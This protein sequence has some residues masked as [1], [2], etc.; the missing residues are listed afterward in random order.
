MR[1]RARGAGELPGHG[2]Q[3][4]LEPPGLCRNGVVG[5]ALRRFLRCGRACVELLGDGVEAVFQ[6][7][8]GG[9]A[10]CGRLARRGH[11]AGNPVE[12]LADFAQGAGCGVAADRKILADDAGKAAGHA[13]RTLAA[14][15][16]GGLQL[17]D[18]RIAFR[19]AFFMSALGLVGEQGLDGVEAMRQQA[20][21]GA[22]VGGR[23]R[24]VAASA[25]GIEIRAV[26]VGIENRID[27]FLERHAGV[28]RRGAGGTP[29][30]LLAG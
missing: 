21:R 19:M 12:P 28:T 10:R 9:F 27:P 1:H 23:A 22:I 13:A 25:R 8:D 4:V 30:I 24:R 26:L 20:R 17:A 2:V 29:D 11:A 15:G 3:L 16:D 14:A 6:P 5:A 7:R 18:Q